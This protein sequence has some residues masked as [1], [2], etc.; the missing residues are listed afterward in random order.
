MFLHFFVEE[1][2]TVTRRE[3][4][5]AGKSD[6]AARPLQS[7]TTV[8]QRHCPLGGRQGTGWLVMLLGTITTIIA[9]FAPEAWARRQCLQHLQAY[10]SINLGDA[11]F[12][13]RP[14]LFPLGATILLEVL[15][16]LTR[17]KQPSKGR[18]LFLLCVPSNKPWQNWW[19]LQA[20]S[21]AHPDPTAFQNPCHG[22]APTPGEDV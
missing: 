18:L 1:N 6:V 20:V 3:K 11:I 21:W 7:S 8:A 22:A 19:W 16:P 12:P 5:K 9:A 15:D 10:P 4:M 17:V 14:G 2:K 13:C